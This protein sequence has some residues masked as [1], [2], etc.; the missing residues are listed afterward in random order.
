MMPPVPALLVGFCFRR[1]YG[2]VSDFSA[3]HQVGSSLSPYILDILNQYG[4]LAPEV[5][6][7][8]S[9]GSPRYRNFAENLKG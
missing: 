1:F 3:F 9:I 8:D 6:R 7:P 4:L 5:N 2:N